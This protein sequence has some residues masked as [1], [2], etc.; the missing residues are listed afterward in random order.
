MT[1]AYGNQVVNGGGSLTAGGGAAGVVETLPES[2]VGTP[3]HT[4]SSDKGVDIG[5]SVLAK[6]HTVVP[7]NGSILQHQRQVII[8]NMAAVPTTGAAAATQVSAVPLQQGGMQIMNMRPAQ[9]NIMQPQ[10][11][12]SFPPRMILNSQMLQG[13]VPGQVS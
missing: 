3:N 11:V 12:R 10:Q 2:R 1:G 4:I 9:G 13:R 5:R 8:S 7:N 6:V